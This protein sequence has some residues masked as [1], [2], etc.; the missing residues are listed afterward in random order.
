MH[1][2]AE[3][4]L[5]LMQSHQDKFRKKSLKIAGF[6]E[7]GLGGRFIF[8]KKMNQIREFSFFLSNEER[9]EFEEIDSLIK[10][11]TPVLA[12]TNDICE[13]FIS[14][15]DVI[16]SDFSLLLSNNEN[17]ITEIHIDNVLKEYTHTVNSVL[18]L[19]IDLCDNFVFKLNKW[20]QQ[21]NDNTKKISE[22][23]LLRTEIRTISNKIK[24]SASLHLPVYDA[25]FNKR[26]KGNSL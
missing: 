11:L 10:E 14:I 25:F 24:I 19:H 26:N 8:E 13:K 9:M 17:S 1:K 23:A 6:F 12:L 2:N 21:I 16:I 18:S 3:F 20:Y 7:D 4:I 5:N 15:G 22:Q